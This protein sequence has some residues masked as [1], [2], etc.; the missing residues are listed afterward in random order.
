MPKYGLR[1]RLLAGTILVAASAVAATAWLSVHGTTTSI[2]QQENVV[3]DAYPLVYDAMVD[4]AATHTTWASAGPVVADVAQE[5]GVRVVVTPVGG[6][7]IESSPASTGDP[8]GAEPAVAIDPLTVDNALAASRFPDGIDPKVA[9]PFQLTTQEHATLEVLAEKEAACLDANRLDAGIAEVASG[10]PYL[11]IA[12]AA[13]PKSCRVVLA[14][15]GGYLGFE[16][17]Q[18]VTPTATEQAAL[19]QLSLSMK[20]CASAVQLTLT[21]TGEVVNTA[22]TADDPRNRACL[23]NARRLQLR[24]YVAPAAFMQAMPLGHTGGPAAVGLS[25]A[26]TVRIA[27]VATLVAL[28]T[29][30]VAMLLANRVIRPVRAL[31]EATRRMRAGDGT[32]RAATSSRWEIAELTAA[33][34]EMAEHVA[35]TDRQRKE[36]VNDISHELRTPLSTIK[37]WLIAAHDGVAALDDELV[38]SLLEEALLLQR[39][40]DDLRDLALAD[41]GRLRL[42]RV[43]L[44]LG[45]LLRHIAA[46][47]GGRAVVEAPPDLRVV[48]DPMRL[49]Q[50]VGNLVANAD[51]HTPAEGRITVRAHRSGPAVLVEVADTGPGIPAEELPYVFDRFW[52]ADKSRNRR[53]GGSGLG[54][55]IVRHLVEAHGGEVS[56]TSVPGAGATFTIRL[57]VTKDSA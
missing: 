45:E 16:D 56:V 50:V 47:G 41:A 35:R 28:F 55:A 42:Q 53:T 9:S 52:R 38:S 15:G 33:F 19:T 49:R 11:A 34:N 27:E 44:D 36:L 54:L 22:G 20:G 46:V 7:A 37:G 3:R 17:S 1:A 10:R 32:A 48:A 39:L 26:D 13:V 25:S 29:V 4:Y 31:T 40:V 24:P 43:E 8:R 2:A 51:R 57:P 18:S 23:L 6:P 30:G 14:Y 21:G 12:E 5:E